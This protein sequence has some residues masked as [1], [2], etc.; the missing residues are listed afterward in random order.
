MS[1]FEGFIGPT[2]T[3]R[4]PNV[5][6][7]RCVNLLVAP[8]Q[9]AEDKQRVSY[10]LTPGLLER[11]SLGAG[12]IRGLFEQDGRAW[13]VAGSSL[14]ELFR[15]YSSTL[16]GDVGS[17]GRAASM[18][19]NLTQLFVLSTGLGF[20]V[21][22]A[23]NAFAQVTDVDFPANVSMGFYTDTYF[24]VLL[25]ESPQF[26]ISDPDNGLS[27]NGAEF[28]RRSEGSCDFVAMVKFKRGIW[29]LGSQDSEVWYNSGAASFPFAPR[30]GVAINTGC[31]AEFSATVCGEYVYWLGGDADGGGVLYRAGEDY[32]PTMVS[33]DAVARI[34]GTYSRLDDAE[35]WTYQKDG[36][37]FYV[38]YFPTADATWVYDAS[39]PPELAWTERLWWDTAAGTYHA[40]RARCHVYAFGK[41]FVGDRA[42]GSVYELSDTVY[43]D[44]GA[45]IRWLRQSPH[46]GSEARTIKH[47]RFQLDMQTGVGLQA[48]QG[49]DP[50]V[51]LQ[52]SDDNGQTWSN[53]YW[54]SLGAVGKYATRVFWR[55]LGKAR[56]RVYRV[57]G[58]DPV[59]I[60]IQ[61]A[62]LDLEGGTN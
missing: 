10:Y 4:S 2:Y 54:R 13:V 59:P 28:G 33:T 53:E 1:V 3:A 47:K 12:P 48:G 49:S 17:D 51:G 61:A 58:T 32:R 45:P 34:W 30:P 44:N 11:W 24:L 35:A 60:A 50:Q 62:Y 46:I 42:T 41:H 8:T 19:Q 43:S 20:V 14:Y 21:T 55:R 31:V 22:L 23:T 40:H 39:L 25:R 52:W 26:N 36:H 9:A 29:L 7:Q 57:F 15:D 6:V 16:I 18:S 27:W 37:D 38:L 56:D 5:S